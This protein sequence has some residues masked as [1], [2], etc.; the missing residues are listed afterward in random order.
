MLPSYALE[1]RSRPLQSVVGLFLMPYGG[2]LSSAM[3]TAAV[4]ASGRPVSRSQA[5]QE[6][7]LSGGSFFP[8]QRYVFFEKSRYFC[9]IKAQTFTSKD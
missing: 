8:A 6:A 2:E 5:L 4:G 7:P 1:I 9:A 3:H